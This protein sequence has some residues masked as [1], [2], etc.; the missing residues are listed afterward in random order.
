M[1]RRG[2]VCTAHSNAHAYTFIFFFGIVVNAIR[3]VNMIN[4]VAVRKGTDVV[5]FLLSLLEV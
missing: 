3:T 4:K 5:S 2:K 1:G